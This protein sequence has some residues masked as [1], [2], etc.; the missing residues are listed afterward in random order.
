MIAV[1]LAVPNESRG[2]LR[3]LGNRSQNVSVLHTGIGE[4]IC[5]ERIGRFLDSNNFEFLLSSGFA[6]GVDP[7]LQV[8]DLLL[9]E[10]F[11]DPQLL[12]RAHA[13][14][15]SRV[16]KLVTA[17]AVIESATDRQQFA[18]QNDAAAVDMETEF[19][20]REC[21]ARKIPMLAL[22]AISD[23]AS[24]PF[25]AP[26]SLLFD[27]D[28]QKT[29]TRKLAAYFLRHP[30]RLVRLIR[31]ARQIATA[32]ANLTSALAAVVRELA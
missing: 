20:A 7:A 13:I 18:K 24:A 14:V 21:A 12:A 2:F 30:S 26:P 27:I 23:T 8:G 3:L 19:I 17:D 9:A 1:T 28:Q 31:F 6:G 5:R 10:N 4:K 25:P 16:G 15:G 29:D 11:S 22:R 32:R